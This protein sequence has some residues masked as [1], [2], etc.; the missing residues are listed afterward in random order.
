MLQV[1]KNYVWDQWYY[2]VPQTVAA[3]LIYDWAK[4]SNAAG[5][6]YVI[7]VSHQINLISQC[8]TTYVICNMPT[9]VRLMF[10]KA[11]KTIL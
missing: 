10:L 8:M 4:K 5:N 11:L 3:Y 2:Y 9:T 6:R 1:F 7:S